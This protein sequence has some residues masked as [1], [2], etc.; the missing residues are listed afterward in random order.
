MNREYLKSR[1][2]EDEDENWWQRRSGMER[3]LFIGLLFAI[4]LSLAC[5][6]YISLQIL[7]NVEV[8]SNTSCLAESYRIATR[9]N[10]T[11]DPCEDFYQYVCGVS[12]E[13]DNTISTLK[14]K[15]N[16]MLVESAG[17]DDSNATNDERKLFDNCLNQTDSENFIVTFQEVLEDIG[18]WPVLVGYHWRARLF[19]WTDAVYSLK[20]RGYPF[21]MFLDVQLQSEGRIK[22][23]IVSFAFPHKGL[24]LQFM[25]DTAV[26]FGADR[27][28]AKLQMENVLS[29]MEELQG[30]AEKNVTLK[31][32]DEL[33][34][35][36]V[37][38]EE[39]QKI[40]DEI[41][42][43]DFLNNILYPYT[44]TDSDVIVIPSHEHFGAFIDLITSIPKRVQA[45]YMVWR[46][47]EEMIPFMSKQLQYLKGNYTCQIESGTHQDHH[48]FCC[49][50]LDAIYVLRPL[51]LQ[52]IQNRLSAKRKLMIEE[53]Y[54]AVKEEIISQLENSRWIDDE[55]RQASVDFFEMT[56]VVIGAPDGYFNGSIF[57]ELYTWELEGESIFEMILS[58]RK[59]YFETLMVM[60][61]SSVML[62]LIK[63]TEIGYSTNTIVLPLAV[64]DEYFDEERPMYLNYAEL[65]VAIAEVLLKSLTDN[66]EQLWSNSTVEEFEERTKCNSVALL[67]GYRSYQKWAES[68]RKEARL[69][70]IEQTPN[71]LF[72]ISAMSSSCHSYVQF[73]PNQYLLKDFMCASDTHFD[74]CDVL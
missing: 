47:I 43:L 22:L 5:V 9:L 37:T 65:G 23:S 68:R 21:S 1:C 62:N 55:S 33:F 28:Q 35:T 2:F 24:Y 51:Q 38:V 11:V 31:R 19:E 69:V 71:Q 10:N 70:A 60:Q 34:G 26:V 66:V 46:V 41:Q 54:L 4:L 58:A 57:E 29:F 45:N 20:S 39:M 52:Y 40:Y 49:E 17:E 59:N 16:E 6:I 61:N 36:H 25:I 67:L 42:W 3:C 8:C 44:V 48:E 50:S 12:P 56:E 27:Y 74:D 73:R 13:R 14:Q 32:P 63:G 72:W 30:V 18:G 7:L 15:V 64:L 53:L